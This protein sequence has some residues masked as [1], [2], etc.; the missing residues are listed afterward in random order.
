MIDDPLKAG[1]RLKV[2]IK[3]IIDRMDSKDGILRIVDYKTGRNK[4]TPATIDDLFPPTEFKKR[5]KEAFQIFYYAYIMSRQP[6]FC[7]YKLA[8]TLLYTRTSSKPTPDDIYYRIGNDAVTDFNSRYGREFEE[9][10]ISIITEIF[11]PDIPFSPTG[12]KETC[13]NCDFS[14]LCGR[15]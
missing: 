12:D 7:K 10:L 6:E 1:S 5:K 15:N 4:G 14:Q 13:R 11:N 9:K 3:G 8:P 2:R